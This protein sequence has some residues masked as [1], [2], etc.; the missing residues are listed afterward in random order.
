MCHRLHERSAF[1]GPLADKQLM[2][3]HVFDS[4]AEIQACRQ[5]TLLA[6]RRIDSGDA[7]R[8]DIGL[9]KV[10]GAKML[11]NVIDRA[12]QVYGAKGL[13]DDSP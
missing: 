6:A 8:I 1:G 11:H 3:L 12:I 5:L 13:T 7:A 10:V 2:Q 9:I 4:L